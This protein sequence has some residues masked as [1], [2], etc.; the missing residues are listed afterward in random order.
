MDIP[1]KVLLPMA[2]GLIA[3]LFAAC[4]P[5]GPGPQ[6]I[7]SYPQSTGPDWSL[8]VQPGGGH[9][10]YSAYIALE[11]RDPEATSN[12]AI[13]IARDY[14]GYLV[15]SYTSRSN[16]EESVTVEVHI[17]PR[18]FEAARR[19]F[20]GLGDIVR[21]TVTGEES[22]HPAGWDGY[23]QITLFLRRQPP[24]FTVWQDIGWN[25]GETLS[26][27][28]KVSGRLLGFTV[29]LLIWLVVILGPFVLI[30]GAAVWVARRL[31]SNHSPPGPEPQAP[32]N[33]PKE[34]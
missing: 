4:S 19:A 3:V 28:L 25:P 7:A 12:K 10:V 5:G 24:R 8:P 18:H 21:E 30:A 14:G 33:S 16:Y 27:A 9:L 34:G 31:R 20:R 13:H 32:Q 15:N 6:Q 26:E 2:L 23:A 22:S 17:P 1:R 29:D 11:L